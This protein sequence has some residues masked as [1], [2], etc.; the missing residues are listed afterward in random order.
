MRER[1]S[2]IDDLSVSIKSPQ[3]GRRTEPVPPNRE[4]P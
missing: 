2:K 3:T 1:G 4:K